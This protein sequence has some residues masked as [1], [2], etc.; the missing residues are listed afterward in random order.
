MLQKNTRARSLEQVEITGSTQSAVGE[1]ADQHKAL[2]QLN[3]KGSILWK[4][5]HCSNEGLGDGGEA[6][7]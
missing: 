6:A 7:E 4:T 1:N 3:I 2:H 5:K